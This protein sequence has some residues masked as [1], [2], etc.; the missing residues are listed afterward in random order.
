MITDF[1]LI[2]PSLIAIALH[3]LQHDLDF[4]EGQY[5]IAICVECIEVL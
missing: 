5:P 3:L 4:I 1:N 2:G